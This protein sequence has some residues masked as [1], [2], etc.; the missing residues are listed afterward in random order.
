MMVA[1]VAIGATLG[2]KR[3][4]HCPELRAEAAEHMLD[5]MIG[6]DPET[7]FPKF[8]RQM[9][10]SEVPSQ[11]YKLLWISVRDLDNMFRGSLNLQPPPVLKLQTISIRHRNSFRK[12]EQDLFTCVRSQSYAAAMA[13]VK[14]ESESACSV[15]LRPMAS[16]AMN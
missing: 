10:V 16:E 3:G 7:L 6:P 5:H 14:I 12:V 2:L 4:L 11:A 13:R 1:V 8:S 9:P 15:F